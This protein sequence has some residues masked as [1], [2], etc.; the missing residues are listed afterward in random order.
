MG[1]AIEEPM[2]KRDIS[3]RGLPKTTEP[4]LT[5]MGEPL[6]LRVA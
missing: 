4:A 6:V 2:K 1:V 5:E 3:Y